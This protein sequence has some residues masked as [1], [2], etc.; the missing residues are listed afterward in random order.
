MRLIQNENMKIYRRPGTWVMFGILIALLLIVG[1]FTK[2]ILEDPV[3]GNWQE[4]VIA[5]NAQYQMMVEEGG[6]PAV[7][8]ERYSRE[9]KLNEYRLEHNIAPVETKSFWGYMTSTVNLIS[10]ITMFTIIVAA[11]IVAGEFTWGT[12]K[13]LLIR[14]ASRAKI[15]LSKYLATFVFAL[16]MLLGLFVFSIA[17]GSLLFGASTLTQPHLFFEAGEV[18]ERNMFSHV[19]MLY[20]LS[21]VELL[22]MVTF[23]FMISTIFRSS[24]LAIG[25]ALFLMFTGSQLV[26]VL[27]QYEWVKYILFANT[28]LVQYIEGTPIVE[29]MTMTFSLIMLAIYFTIFNVLS[30][31]IFQKRDV[32][33]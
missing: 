21:S 5:K 27:S 10:V 9:I 28:Y 31:V 4:G 29:G 33:A 12:I 17:I 24:S 30:W 18:V 19:L 3:Y 26:H 14:P 6:M 22:M 1:L 8:L 23:A 20:S 15:L 11:G 2:Y 25:L 13:L 7:A 32:A 16:L